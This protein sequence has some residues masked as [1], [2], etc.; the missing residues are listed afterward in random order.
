MQAP[1]VLVPAGAL[2]PGAATAPVPLPADTA[3][4][5]RRV[6]RLPAGAALEL[7][8]GGGARAPAVLE[9]DAARLTGPVVHE[10]RP[11][12]SLEV[13]QAL[14]KGR[15]LDDVVRVLTE[16]GVDRLLPVA[17]ERSVVRLSGPRADRAVERWRAVAVAACEQ[18]RRTWLPRL[19]LP[20]SVEDVA[21][22]TVGATLVVAHV[23]GDH[24]LRAA[25]EQVAD[26]A[27]ERV[28]LAVGPEG[29]W[30]DAEVATLADAGGQVVS[31]GPTVL[32]TEHAAPALVA[33]AGYVLGRLG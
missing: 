13:A 15:K 16:L 5:L 23:G 9:G 6:L 8:D 1:F 31:L 28:V 29:G 7:A 12:P 11:A 27:P 24:P 32:R 25:M 30:T 17:S 4:H 21:T 18:S 2:D 10:P 14:P 3:A 22:E 19:D 26:R 33:V 20:A